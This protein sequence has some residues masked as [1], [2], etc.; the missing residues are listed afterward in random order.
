MLLLANAEDI[1]VS[2]SSLTQV[3]EM[4]VFSYLHW[5]DNMRFHNIF[6]RIRTECNV[7]LTICEIFRI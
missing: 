5:K 7:N 4:L 1:A 3:G 2:L 6:L